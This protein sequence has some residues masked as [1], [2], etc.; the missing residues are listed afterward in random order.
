MLQKI[1]QASLSHACV[2]DSL[3]AECKDREGVA[4]VG[5]ARVGLAGVEDME[6]N[7]RTFATSAAKV[8][9]GPAIVATDDRFD[10]R[11]VLLP[12]L[13]SSMPGP[14]DNRQLCLCNFPGW[15]NFPEVRTHRNVSEC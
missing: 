9:T 4:R 15:F 3:Q 10:Q 14:L 12:S 8:V 2:H 1:M 11:S 7:L 5:V 13:F 6:T